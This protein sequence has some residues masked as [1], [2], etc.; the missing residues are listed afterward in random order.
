ML[1]DSQ[2]RKDVWLMT[3]YSDFFIFCDPRLISSDK[4][5]LIMHSR[6]SSNKRE[7]TAAGWKRKCLA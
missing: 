2:V 6:A 3:E 5:W 7:T 1:Q 4:P